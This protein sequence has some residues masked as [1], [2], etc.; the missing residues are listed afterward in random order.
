MNLFLKNS[1]RHEWIIWTIGKCHQDQQIPTIVGWEVTNTSSTSQTWWARSDKSPRNHQYRIQILHSD[2]CLANRQNLHLKTLSWLQS[3]RSTIYQTH[4]KQNTTGEEHKNAEIALMNYYRNWPLSQE[5]IKGAMEKVPSSWLLAL[6]IKAIGYA[7]NKQEFTDT[8]CMRYG[9]K[10]KGI[11]THCA[12]RETTLW[13]TAS[14]VNWVATLQWGTT[15]W[16][17]LR[18][19]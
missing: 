17:T 4:E 14:Y 1:T 9:W 3:P 8:I 2:H 11:P 10:V 5:L 19:R 15:Q 6:P 13:I 18:H 12:C 7:L 16:E